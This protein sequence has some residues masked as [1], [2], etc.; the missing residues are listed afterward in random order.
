M[1]RERTLHLLPPVNIGNGKAT[2]IGRTRLHILEDSQ[3][4]H[5]YPGI[6][7]G[8][9]GCPVSKEHVRCRRRHIGYTGEALYTLVDFGNSRFRKKDSLGNVHSSARLLG[10]AIP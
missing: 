3:V 9:L 1:V 2:G 10:N 7:K 5:E 8:V 6:R 4:E